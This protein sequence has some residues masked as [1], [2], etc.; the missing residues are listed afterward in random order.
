ML[1]FVEKFARKAF[2]R[3]WVIVHGHSPTFMPTLEKAAR[4]Y[5]ADSGHKAPLRIVVSRHF[6]KEPEKYKVDIA[7]LN[8]LCREPTIETRESTHQGDVSNVIQNK[9]LEIL[10]ECICAQT[11]VIVALGGRWWDTARPNARVAHEIDLARS[12]RLPCFPLVG[13]GGATK[14]YLDENPN[15]I[16]Q[17]SVGLTDE[18]QES[19]FVQTDPE[20]LS[21]DILAQIE[22]LPL[23]QRNSTAG[24]P[25]RILSLD[26]GGV[27][28]AY[29]A[30]A[31]SYWETL[32]GLRTCDHF[33]LICGTSTGGII[34]IGLGLG[35]PASEL[36]KF[37]EEDAPV[38]FAAEEGT[39]DWVH[40][41]RHWF[42]SKY[43][44]CVLEEAI[45]LRLKD[46]NILLSDSKCRLLIPYFNEETD[47]PGVFRTPHGPAGRIHRGQQAVPVALA[48][49]AAPTYFEPVDVGGE[50]AID[51]GV[52]ANSPSSVALHEAV[53][54]LGIDPDR[55]EM[56][57]IGTTFSSKVM[58]APLLIDR[59]VVGS[60]LKS[61]GGLFL[62]FFANLILSTVGKT[63][64][65]PKRVR[66][67]IGYAPNIAGLLMKT[68]AQAADY[69]VKGVLDSRYLRIDTAA[70]IG[71]LDAVSEV[72][73]LVS[74]GK[75]A[76]K[77][78]AE[79]VKVRFYNGVPVSAPDWEE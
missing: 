10:R 4:E 51:G 32:T 37:Y 6:S 20:A 49:T 30:A 69:V 67:K 28:G 34:A 47:L 73:K 45:K 1:M 62:G 2:A 53:G 57:S 75:E 46:E 5:K 50:M 22:R 3:G 27:R 42:R 23:G 38:I 59:K 56:L 76:A 78:H 31:L 58:S 11:N 36:V 24:R 26:G 44:Q 43:D 77:T 9:S 52:W 68:Q 71:A 13:L 79:A 21:E 33:D 54:Y 65:K 61:G 19:L 41:L 74:L 63:L 12:H 8:G 25:F 39:Q 60:L 7:R 29:T 48:T 14:S 16:K 70:D 72:R 18:Q 17:N 35:I 55:I 66:G 15:I 64:W 40:T